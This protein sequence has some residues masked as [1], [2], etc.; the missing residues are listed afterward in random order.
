VAAGAADVHDERAMA[1]LVKDAIVRACEERQAL[2]MAW[3]ADDG[4]EFVLTGDLGLYDGCKVAADVSETVTIAVGGPAGPW[5]D[6]TFYP[7]PT[8]Q[9]MGLRQIWKREVPASP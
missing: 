5:I 6:G 2:T 1:S 4:S 8:A 9:R 3:M 7:L